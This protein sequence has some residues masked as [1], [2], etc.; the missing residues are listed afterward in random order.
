MIKYF[1]DHFPIGSQCFEGLTKRKQEVFKSEGGI[2]L[3]HVGE[4]NN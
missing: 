1:V 4:M 2:T 3:K